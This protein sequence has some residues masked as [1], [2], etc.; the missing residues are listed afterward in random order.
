MRSKL[1][2][3]SSSYGYSEDSLDAAY[4]EYLQSTQSFEASL[5]DRR[6]F[7]IA[8]L[9]GGGLECIAPKYSNNV[10]AVAGAASTYATYEGLMASTNVSVY[11]GILCM[12]G[13]PGAIRIS[14]CIP[15]SDLLSGLDKVVQILTKA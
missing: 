8:R 6:E 4:G 13:T 7:T 11:P 5:V 3:F 10:L 1:H 15:S 14:P 2:L 9:N 12:Q